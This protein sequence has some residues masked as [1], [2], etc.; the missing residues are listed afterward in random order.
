MFRDLSVGPPGMGRQPFLRLPGGKTVMWGPSSSA[1]LP[2]PLQPPLPQKPP[3]TEP[4]RTWARVRRGPAASRCC[5]A[6]SR[7][8][9]SAGVAASPVHRR[10]RGIRPTRGCRCC[11]G[12]AGLGRRPGPGGVSGR[13]SSRRGRGR[14][15]ASPPQARHPLPPRLLLAFWPIDAR[16][17]RRATNRERSSPPR[18]V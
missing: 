8:P 2:L 11:R 9:S 3:Q 7:R 6:G 1:Y 16:L 5:R 15:R 13:S 10:Y 14:G 4:A 17:G 12:T 18:R